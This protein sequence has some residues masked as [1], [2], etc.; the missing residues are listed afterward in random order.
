M[1]GYGSG[2]KVSS[3]VLGCMRIAQMEHDQLGQLIHRCLET[4]INAFD[5]ADIYRGGQ[6]EANFGKILEEQP[7]LRNQMFIQSKCGI[8]RGMYDFS[9]NHILE[10][11]DGSLKRL[12][13]DYLD[14]LILHRP[15][16]LMEPEEVAEAFDILKKTGKVRSFGVSNMNMMQIELLQNY[17]N[18]KLAVNQL[19]LSLAH[20]LMLDEGFNVNMPDVPGQMHTG[21]ILDYCRLKGIGIQS[22][23]PLQYGFIEGTFL[24]SEKYPELNARLDALAEKYNATSGAIAIAWILRIPGV[25]QAVIGTTKPDRITELSKAMNIKLTKKEWYELYLSAG[26]RIP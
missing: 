14:L 22:W 15:D 23:S 20:T 16:L 26:N 7:A 11:V 24:G 2:K 5:H 8:C 4:G 9:K 3:I 13:T 10:S 19:Q 1:T 18:D 21:G 17:I 6:S 12:H 25:V